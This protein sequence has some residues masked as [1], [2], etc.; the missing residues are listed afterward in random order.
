MDSSQTQS[1]P[2]VGSSAIV[3]PGVGDI[4]RD[5]CGHKVTL[6]RLIDHMAVCAHDYLAREMSYH[7]QEIDWTNDKAQTQQGQNQNKHTP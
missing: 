4:G 5:S 7:W 2:E 6:I 1:P 3:R